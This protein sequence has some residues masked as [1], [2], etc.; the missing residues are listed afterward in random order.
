MLKSEEDQSRLHAMFSQLKNAKGA[1][2]ENLIKAADKTVYANKALERWPREELNGFFVNKVF[3]CL[4]ASVQSII[5]ITN[6]EGS[7]D[8]PDFIIYLKNGLETKV[9]RW[10]INMEL[11]VKVLDKTQNVMEFR[12]SESYKRALG[13]MIVMQIKGYTGDA[14][15]RH[16]FFSEIERIGK[17]L[18]TDI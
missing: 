7:E 17:L 14:E 8:G 11:P 9:P 4:N 15:F 2:A 18:D 16:K 3:D 12:D 10:L 5:P 13:M 6:Y 1:S